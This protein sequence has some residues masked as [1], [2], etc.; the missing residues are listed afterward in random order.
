MPFGLKRLLPAL[1]KALFLEDID[2]Y[3]EDAKDWTPEELRRG[4]RER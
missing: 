3:W 2:L 1:S 4:Q